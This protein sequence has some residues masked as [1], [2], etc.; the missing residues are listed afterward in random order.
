M[1]KKS[2]RTTT[3]LVDGADYFAANLDTGGIRVGLKN[4]ACID[5]PAG[6]KLF[7]A[8]AA[9]TT[10]AEADEFFSQHLYS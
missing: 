9:I 8:A 5:I 1:A 4:A 2:A 6:H 10:E 7:D 3:F